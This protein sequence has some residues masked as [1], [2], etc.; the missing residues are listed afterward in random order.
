[1]NSASSNNES[2]KIL[3]PQ[4]YMSK[5]VILGITTNHESVFKY[6][7]QKAKKISFT[8]LKDH[9]QQVQRVIQTPSMYIFS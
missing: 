6:S 5:E 7:Q 2:T 1:M 3:V 4:E 8:H 9:I